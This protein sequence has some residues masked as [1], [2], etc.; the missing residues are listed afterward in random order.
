MRI[1]TVSV[2]VRYSKQMADGS[3]KTV[4]LGCEGTLTSGDE[5]WYEVQAHLYHQLGDQMKQ[6]FSGNGSGKAQNGPEKPVETVPPPPL[7]SLP[8]PPAPLRNHYC[9]EHETVFEKYAKDGRTWYSH[10]A[11]DGKW[12]REA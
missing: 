6:V 5:D 4:E 3:F 11:S 9:Q 1:N 7:P 10:K 8:S 2:S 12:H